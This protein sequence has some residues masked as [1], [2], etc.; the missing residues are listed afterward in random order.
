[1]IQRNISS[2]LPIIYLFTVLLSIFIIHLGE[3]IGAHYYQIE[4]RNIDKNKKKA[5]FKKTKKKAISKISENETLKADTVLVSTEELSTSKDSIKM[6]AATVSDS[7]FISNLIGEYHSKWK[8]SKGRISRTDVVIRYYKKNKDEDRVYKL[9]DLGFYIH[10]RP[11]E[12]D[13]DDYESN[14][15]FYGDSIKRED[16]ILIAHNLIQNGVKLQSLTL[17]KFHAAWKAHSV[18][19]GTDTTALGEKPL[20]LA[21]LRKKWE[22]M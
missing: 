11:A 9:R 10:E 6:E 22:S 16:L 13:F 17:S 19:I 4:I 12:D 2:Y 8:N 3:V 14:A 15:I 5:S 7:D 20:T 18:E 1:M 21:T